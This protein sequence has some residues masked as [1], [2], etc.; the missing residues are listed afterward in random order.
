MLMT[1]KGQIILQ[2]TSNRIFL[3]REAISKFLLY[4]VDC[5]RKNAGLTDSS[6]HAN[7]NNNPGSNSSGVTGAGGPSVKSVKIAQRNFTKSGLKT[8]SFAR[9]KLDCS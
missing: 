5:Q 3:F 1:K 4:C 8:P 2:F 7:A 9:Y 6:S